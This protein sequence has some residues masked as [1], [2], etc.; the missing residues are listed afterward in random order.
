MDFLAGFKTWIGVIVTFVVIVA[1]Q[2][3]LNF[4]AD[5]LAFISEAWDKGIEAGALLF[6]GFGLIMKNLRD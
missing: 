4:G 1:P 2:L 3:G 6:A 5:D